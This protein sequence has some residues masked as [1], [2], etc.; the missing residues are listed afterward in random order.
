MTVEP[1]AY[2]VLVVGAG[3]AGL[4]AA[5]YLAKAGL[6]A[7]LCEKENQTGGLVN[8]F[9]YKGFVFDGGIR[10]I[11]DSG[12][13]S[14]MLRQLGLR[15]EFL[16]N[17]VS[18]GIG[19]DVITVSSKESLRSYQELLDKHFPDNKQDIA[20]I[21]REIAKIMQ[22]MDVLYGIDNPLFLD[23]KNNPKYVFRTILPWV[24]KYLLTAPKIAKLRKPVDEY[25][26]GFSTN[27]A[28]L[29]IIAQ[30]FFQKT[31][32]F[33]ALSYFSLYLD[34]R[35]PRGGTG[36]L[37]KALEQFV[38]GKNGEIRRETEITRVD[39]GRHQA[40]D[41][42]GNVYQYKKLVWAA[43]LKTLYRV[44]DLASLTD[45]KVIGGIETRKATL[46]GKIGGDSVFT[47][48][49]TVDL[50]GAHF[51]QISSPHFFYT[52]SI[53]GLSQVNLDELRNDEPKIPAGF[54]DDRPRIE[55]WLGRFLDYTTYEI[56][57]PVLRDASLAPAGKTGLIISS[58]FDY[59]LTKHIEAMGWY[60]EF[61]KLVADRMIQVLDA[62]IYPGLKAAR[63]D[64]FTSTP[65]TIRR[66]SGN[67]EGAITGWAFTND[68]IPAVNSLPRVASSVLTPIP[69]AYQAGQWTYSP[70][71]LPIAILTGKLAADRVLKDLA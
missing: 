61:R 13:V 1:L 24:F 16:P 51:A 18:V 48:Y 68:F 38:L 53:T 23:L 27:R 17:P 46:A 69:D 4:T 15:V 31:P 54:V 62:S 6:K 66:F 64:S 71:G 30:H 47:L 55:D 44:A 29:D 70:S 21:I 58:L 43:D 56:S 33:F 5:A 36:A 11:E 20:G 34:Y 9:E 60:D 32:T 42:R 41:A 63:I 35:Y 50:E 2:D 14:S 49:L 8:S 12:I 67:S 65:L 57:Y 10:A 52:P 59:S 28:L 40:T 45:S 37:A 19:Q 3:M 39:P 25:L 7:L 22:Y 26:A